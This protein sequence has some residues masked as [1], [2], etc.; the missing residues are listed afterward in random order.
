M[1]EELGMG[2]CEVGV[3]GAQVG[4]WGVPAEEKRKGHSP[5][6]GQSS[7]GM[8]MSLLRKQGLQWGLR[9]GRGKQGVLDASCL[10]ATWAGSRRLGCASCSQ[11]HRDDKVTTAARCQQRQRPQ[12]EPGHSSLKGQEERTQDREGRRPGSDLHVKSHGVVRGSQKLAMC[13]ARWRL[14]RPHPS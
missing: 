14:L 6:F 8:G 13:G 2:K 7:H 12:S 5:V 9:L 10:G 1:G 3:L 11:R 4:Y